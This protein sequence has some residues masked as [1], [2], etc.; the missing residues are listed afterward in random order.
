MQI[1]GDFDGPVDEFA[2]LRDLIAWLRERDVQF[3]GWVSGYGGG[4]NSI[5]GTFRSLAEVEA[6]LDEVETEGVRES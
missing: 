5:G 2:L 4:A 1:D 3:S 6:A